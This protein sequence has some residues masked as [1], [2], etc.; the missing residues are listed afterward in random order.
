ML[1]TCLRTRSW[2]QPIITDNNVTLA[3]TSLADASNG[4]GTLATI[5]FA[6]VDVNPSTIKFTSALLSD[7]E[8]NQ[9]DVITTNGQITGP[10]AK[11]IPCRCY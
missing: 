9:L 1:I 7:P 5:T 11:M 6:V 2:S 3:A 10:A 4:D 8:A